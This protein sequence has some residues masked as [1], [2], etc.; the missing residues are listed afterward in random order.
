[1]RQTPVLALKYR[2]EYPAFVAAAFGRAPEVKSPGYQRDAPV[3][4]P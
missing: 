1:M 3:Y 4:L 2:A